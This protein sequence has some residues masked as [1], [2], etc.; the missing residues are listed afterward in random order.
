MP[1]IVIVVKG[2]M[3]QDVYSTEESIDVTVMDLDTEE[4]LALEETM[5]EVRRFL[6][7]RHQHLTKYV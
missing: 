2:G 7:R 5:Q 6:N 3:V 4:G 1:E